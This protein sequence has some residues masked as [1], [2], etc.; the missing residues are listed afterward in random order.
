MLGATVERQP[1]HQ[2][3]GQQSQPTQQIITNIPAT[4]HVPRGPAAV[5]NIAAPR[6]AVAT[7]IGRAS[8]VQPGPIVRPK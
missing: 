2:P 4:F 6:S 3:S 1:Q 5:A 7:P 8:I